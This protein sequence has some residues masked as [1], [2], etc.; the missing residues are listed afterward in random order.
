M[1]EEIFI[2]K[3]IFSRTHNILLSAGS[4]VTVDSSQEERFNK[5]D[6]K[7]VID[8]VLAENLDGVDF[9]GKAENQ[10]TIKTI[11]FDFIDSQ[12]KIRHT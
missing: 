12:S 10:E 5:S 1:F 7:R 2:Q 11:F 9:N 6:V 8:E 3:I 4:Y